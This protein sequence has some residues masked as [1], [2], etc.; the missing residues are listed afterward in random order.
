MQLEIP[1]TFD[2]FGWSSLEERAQAER[3]DL[4]GLVSQ[5]CAYYE[6]EL[7]T[8]RPATRASGFGPPAGGEARALMIELPEESFRRLGREA[9]L[10]GIPFE[11]LLA[12]AALLYLADVDAGRVGERI[13][14]RSTG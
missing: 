11:R 9:D 8:G 12:H 14:R 1:I 13:V 4:G 3:L 6:S 10:Q 2:E 7:D 5:A